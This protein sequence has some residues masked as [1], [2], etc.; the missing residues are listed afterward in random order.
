MVLTFDFLC[1]IILF[2]VSM[3]RITWRS[4]SQCEEHQNFTD[5]RNEE[6][7]SISNR[8]IPLAIILL[9][10]AAERLSRLAERLM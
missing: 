4:I 9:L 6:Q 10:G 3:S 1:R 2:E 7:S 5:E 8:A